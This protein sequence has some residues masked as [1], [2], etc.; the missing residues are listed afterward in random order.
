MATAAFRASASTPRTAVQVREMVLTDIRA[1]WGKFSED[2][3]SALT[4]RDD[5]V[6]QIVAKYGYERVQV[7]HDVDALLKGRQV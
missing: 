1:T 6:A 4:G 7:Q 3:L 5:L 2:D